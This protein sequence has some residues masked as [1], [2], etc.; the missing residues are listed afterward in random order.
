MSHPCPGLRDLPVAPFDRRQFL[1]G[2]AAV[3]VACV[4]PS[5]PSVAAA[6]GIK[7]LPLHQE[8]GQTGDGV[9]DASRFVGGQAAMAERPFLKVVPAKDGGEYNAVGINHMK[10][11]VADLQDAPRR[12]KSAFLVT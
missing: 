3:V 6:P 5:V 2:V 9:R 11:I 1:T 12:G 7:T 4:V 10:A 8:F